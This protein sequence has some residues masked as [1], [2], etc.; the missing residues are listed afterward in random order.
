[1]DAYVEKRWYSSVNHRLEQLGCKPLGFGQSTSDR[2]VD[3]QKILDSPFGKIPL[4]ADL[5]EDG[6]G[7]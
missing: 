4:I 3:A 2:L 6:D 1:M 5:R 7:E